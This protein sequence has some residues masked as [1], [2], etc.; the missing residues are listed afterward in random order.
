VIDDKM[1]ISNVIADRADEQD[2]YKNVYEKW[3][4][5]KDHPSS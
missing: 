4:G 1:I 3:R 2:A 5:K